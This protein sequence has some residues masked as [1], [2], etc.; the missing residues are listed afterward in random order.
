MHKCPGNDQRWAP[1][2]PVDGLEM[3]RTPVRR[4]L[5][6]ASKFGS[7]GALLCLVSSLTI[8]GGCSD[9]SSGN[10]A[11]TDGSSPQDS[12]TTQAETGGDAGPPPIGDPVT[13]CG[14]CPV[15]GGALASATVGVSY[16]T[17]NCQT[18]TDCVTG[19][20][21]LPDPMGSQLT[22]ECLKTCHTDADCKGIFVCRSDIVDARSVCWS[23]Y[24]P[25]V[26]PDA[27]S[28]GLDSGGADAAPAADASPE[29]G[30]DAASGSDA[31]TDSGLDA[32]AM[33]KDAS[34]SGG[35]G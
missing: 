22:K 30:S 15:C 29:A 35:P 3:K 1:R 33:D 2:R 17:Q 13:S 24:P 5:I 14:N 23:S 8:L 11:G 26:V 31:T 34:D 10:D 9:S 20:A 28:G 16:C 32:G 18:D 21:C 19:T 25:P 6:E 27:G 7:A 4:L 12:P